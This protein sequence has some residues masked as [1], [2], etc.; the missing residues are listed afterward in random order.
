MRS[1]DEEKG[2]SKTLAALKVKVKW[3]KVKN[4]NCQ[5][6]LSEEVRRKLKRVG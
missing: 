1:G 2:D 6:Q 5:Q 3:W 4:G